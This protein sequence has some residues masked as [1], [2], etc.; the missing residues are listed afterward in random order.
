[1]R[2]SGEGEYEESLGAKARVFSTR[3]VRSVTM[4]FKIAVCKMLNKKTHYWN[5][6]P[7]LFGISIFTAE[8]GP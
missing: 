6:P 5:S 8:V 3:E 7:V 2:P 4:S 1:M